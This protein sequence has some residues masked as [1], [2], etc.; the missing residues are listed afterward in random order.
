MKEINKKISLINFTDSNRGTD[1][2]KWLVIHYVG[3]VSTAKNNA[4]Y[5]YSVY[6][7]ASAHFFVDENEIWQVVE[8]ND[9]AWHCGA[10]K[11]YSEC[12]NST[13]IGI[14]MCVK[15]NGQW[16][17][18]D[19]TV[20]NTIELA[21]YICEKYG[22]DRNHVIRHYDVSHKV[23]P[24]P[25][26]RNEAAWEAFKDCIFDEKTER[27]EPSQPAQTEGYT[28]RITASV[29]NVRNE[30]NTNSK[31][32]TQVRRNEVYTIVAEQG[33]WGRLKSG[34]GW[35]CLDYTE[36][37]SAGIV[38]VEPATKTMKV[39]TPSG[40]NV[41][42]V[43]GG[44]KVGAIPNGTVVT[45]YEES[46]GW[47]RIGNGQWVSSQYLAPT[48]AQPSQPQT[49]TFR[50]GDIVRIKSSAQK[51][52]TGQTIPSRYKNQAYTIMQK[53]EGKSLLQ[54]IMSWVY[55]KDLTK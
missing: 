47:S 16:Y 35:I 6:R 19:A 3:A 36:K 34:A 42:N 46:N 15:N 32:N 13:S 14:E 33:N 41:R 17:F 24:E 1:Q 26:V 11:Y 22:I 29:L 25:Y 10:D 2:I 54:Q 31:I 45:V 50:K 48:N 53:E 27:P 9:T 30:P 49:Q 18:E 39:N 28:V 52:V 43:P 5:F 44:A 12:R 51:Y 55:D 20:Q 4:D 7:G 23:C 8:E 40:V 37:T 21:K 38:P